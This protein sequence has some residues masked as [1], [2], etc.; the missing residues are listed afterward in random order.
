MRTSR[1]GT[2]KP[3]EI[4]VALFIILAVGLVMLRLFQNQLAQQ[5]SDLANV[6]QEQRIKELREDARLYCSQKCTE[7]SN[8]RCSPSSMASLCMSYG[9]NA[10]PDGWVDL[11]MN[12]V[13]DLDTTAFGGVGVCEDAIPCSLLID[14]CCG[15]RITP[16]TCLDIKKDYWTSLAFNSTE[17][18]NTIIKTM[19]TGN[20]T[21]CNASSATLFWYE[22][23]GR[24]GLS[25]FN[26]S[27]NTF[28]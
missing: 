24:D 19:K 26:H 17:I 6:E 1:K 25:Y 22:I 28:P 13:S 18:N 4:F 2:E 14:E 27:G 15:R 3:I 23:S 10:V 12:Q 9:T 7:A 21:N 20:G 11:N 8:N 16:G 5:Q